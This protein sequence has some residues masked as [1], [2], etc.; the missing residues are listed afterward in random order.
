MDALKL[1]AT[2]IERGYSITTLAKALG[3]SSDG[4]RKRIN[5]RIRFKLNE[6]VDIARELNLR[7]DEIE[8]IFFNSVAQNRAN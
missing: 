3:I 4:L 8:K 7:P 6:I 2:I 5:G 1:K